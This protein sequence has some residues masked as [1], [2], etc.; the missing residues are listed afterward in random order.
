MYETRLGRLGIPVRLMPRWPHWQVTI[1]CP[2]LIRTLPELPQDPNDPDDVDT[3]AEDHAFDCIKGLFLA[4]PVGPK[5]A[6]VYSREPTW[7]GRSQEYG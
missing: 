4:R 1:N 2:N 7:P 5:G 6:A 3:T